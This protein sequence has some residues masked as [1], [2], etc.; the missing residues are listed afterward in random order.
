[1]LRGLT[2]SQCNTVQ[3]D[4]EFFP[5]AVERNDLSL[6]FNSVTTLAAVLTPRL[7]LD[8]THNARQQPRGDWHVLTDS[9]GALLPADENLNYTL[10]S[11]VTWSPSPALSFTLT[12]EYLA[13]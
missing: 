1:M 6:D 5:F 2:A 8:V 9:A 10:R 11:R 13:S 4:Y 3:A 7:T 12:P